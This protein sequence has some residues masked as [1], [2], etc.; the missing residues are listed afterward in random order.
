VLAQSQG[1]VLGTDFDRLESP[2]PYDIDQYRNGLGRLDLPWIPLNTVDAL[3][4]SLSGANSAGKIA[5]IP[6]GWLERDDTKGVLNILPHGESGLTLVFQRMFGFLPGYYGAGATGVVP[7]ILHPK[8]SAG[9]VQ[10]PAD[11]TTWDLWEPEDAESLTDFWPELVAEYQKAIS[12][13]AAGRIML[14]VQT[15]LDRGGTSIAIDGLSRSVSPVL[16]QRGQEAIQAAQTWAQSVRDEKRG[17]IMAF[18]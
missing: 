15:Q 16:L 5:E 4:L 9:L 10:L 14:Q 13:M 11:P 18:V 8:Y 12:Q 6:V 7:V 1:E 17:L 3:W 2:L